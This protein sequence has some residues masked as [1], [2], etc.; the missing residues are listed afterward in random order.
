[1]VCTRH[2]LRCSS[3]HQLKPVMQPNQPACGGRES[4]QS[5]EGQTNQPPVCATLW[6]AVPRRWGGPRLVESWLLGTL[7]LYLLEGSLDPH[8]AFPVQHCYLRHIPSRHQA[9]YHG[10]FGVS[11][12]T[13]PTLLELLQRAPTPAPSRPQG[14]AGHYIPE[15]LPRWVL[16]RRLA[17]AV[18]E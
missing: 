15:C 3:F 1:M 12:S 5:F 11:A 4:G 7:R 16:L 9:S 6:V 14:S 17:A 8:P 2:L 10:G 13:E 18:G